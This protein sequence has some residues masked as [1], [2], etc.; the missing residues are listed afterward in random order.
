MIGALT[1]SNIVKRVFLSCYL[2]YN[3]VKDE[4]NMGYMTQAVKQRIEIMFRDYGFYRI[5]ANIMPRN[6]MSLKVLKNYM[7]MAAKRLFPRRL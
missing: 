4:I 3:L 7:K 1:F 2:G 5:E 6:I